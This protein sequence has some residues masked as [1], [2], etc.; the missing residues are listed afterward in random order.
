MFSAID[1]TN[2]A[3]LLIGASPI[4]SFD[5]GSTESEVAKVIYPQV[6]D[7]LLGMFNWT[8]AETREQLARELVPATEDYAYSYVLPSDFIRAIGLDDDAG[9][10]VD[11]YRIV[12]RH[13]AVDSTKAYLTYTKRVSEQWFPAYFGSVLVYMLAAEFCVPIT[14]DLARAQALNN[15]FRRNYAAAR[16]ADSQQ[17]TPRVVRD[18]TLT[19]VRYF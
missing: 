2:R 16:N 1:Y 13:V 4:N 8:F 15:E 18:D 19:S 10:A 12:G 6:R 17:D 14:E 9:F 11:S 3:L 5:D 7:S